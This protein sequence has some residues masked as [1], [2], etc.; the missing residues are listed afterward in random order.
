[1]NSSTVKNAQTVK[2]SLGIVFNLSEKPNQIEYD[3]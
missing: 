3:V 1:M 2:E